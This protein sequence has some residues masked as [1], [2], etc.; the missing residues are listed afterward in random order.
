[1]MGTRWVLSR[2]G[3]E[4]VDKIGWGRDIGT[5]GKWADG[6]PGIELGGNPSIV[7]ENGTKAIPAV[8]N[9]RGELNSG[10]G[11]VQ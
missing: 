1:M 3:R 2:I 10:G 8:E 9:H 11:M 7:F 5:G 6:Q 4:G